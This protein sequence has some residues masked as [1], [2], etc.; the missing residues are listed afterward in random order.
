MSEPIQHLGLTPGI[1]Y[2]IS[3]ANYHADLLCDRP[4]LSRS[5]A[6]VILEQSPLHLWAKHPRLGAHGEKKVTKAMDFG[7][8]SHAI[9]LGQGADI[10]AVD[11]DNWQTKDARAQRDAIRESG[12][13]PLLQK[14]LDAANQTVGALWQRLKEFNLYDKFTAAKSEVVLLWDESDHCS[15][16]VMADKLLIDEENGTADFFDIK[17][18]DSANPKWLP[19]HFVDMGYALQEQFYIHG[20]EQVL[21]KFAGRMTFTFILQETE[22]PFV[23]VPV[24][25]S[26]EFRGASISKVMRATDTWGK[27]RQANRWPGYTKEILTLEAPEWLLAQEI[28]AQNFK[29]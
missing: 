8:A 24:R 26:G 5:E 28:G 19:R 4:T 21:P 3:E 15:C 27:C 18:T 16:R 9:A 10:V 22:Y 14:D 12:K 17:F 7:S 13:T 25:L 2:G 20:L 29:L 11:A 23:M 1:H 6:K